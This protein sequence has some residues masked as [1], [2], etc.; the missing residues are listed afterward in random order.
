MRNLIFYLI[1]V[2]DEYFMPTMT[3]E[4]TSEHRSDFRVSAKDDQYGFIM[5]S[6][7]S[8]KPQN[9]LCIA[10]HTRQHEIC[11]TFCWWCFQVLI[12]SA[13]ILPCLNELSQFP[14][15]LE[16]VFWE[17]MNA[18]QP[19]CWRERQRY[20]RSH[21]THRSRASVLTNA[22]SAESV[23]WPV[24]DITS[25]FSESCAAP[26]G[27]MCVWPLQQTQAQQ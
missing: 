8:M 6:V 19:L 20:Q 16:A 3:C 11:I 2:W 21:K 24:M 1:E 10:F 9:T 14:P 22:A 13:H 27:L 7:P 26:A 5:A 17:N 4:G 18:E 12:F 23:L 15:V 25:H